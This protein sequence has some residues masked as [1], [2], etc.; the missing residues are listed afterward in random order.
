MK[1]LIIISLSSILFVRCATIFNT[2]YQEITIEADQKEAKIYVDNQYK[3]DSYVTTK[4]KRKDNHVIKVEKFGFNDE[5]YNLKNVTDGKWLIADGVAC[6]AVVGIPALLV[7]LANGSAKKFPESHIKIPL[8]PSEFILQT[9]QNDKANKF[10]EQ[11]V[12]KNLTEEEAWSLISEIVTNYFDNIETLDGK[13][14]YIK[15][16]W[17]AQSFGNATVRS[18]IIITKGGVDPLKYRIKL[19]S[20]VATAN[21]VSIKADE[22][23][24]EWDRI[25]NKYSE[26]INEFQRRLGN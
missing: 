17:Y 5:F 16:D 10:Y 15:T 14:G 7:D 8:K 1:Q 6:F 4:V 18:R 11:T 9:T 19:V 23:F 26:L 12:S 24:K 2:P 22:Q 3:G 25:L 20:E 21:N 13:T